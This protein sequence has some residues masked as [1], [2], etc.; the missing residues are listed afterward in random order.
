MP[1]RSDD[2]NIRGGL[3]PL[4]ERL[5]FA[6]EDSTCS[7]VLVGLLD[8]SLDLPPRELRIDLETDEEL[9]VVRGD[10]GSSAGGVRDRTSSVAS[11][12]EPR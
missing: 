4:G 9:L 6:Q 11:P 10:G 2:L 3:P 8:G 1:E 12:Q 5:E 7:G